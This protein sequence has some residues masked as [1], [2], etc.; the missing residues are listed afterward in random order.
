MDDF[1]R[2]VKKDDG[3]E[4]RGGNCDGGSMADSIWLVG[5]GKGVIYALYGVAFFNGDY[6]EPVVGVCDFSYCFSFMEEEMT[7]AFAR[8]AKNRNQSEPD[9]QPTV[10]QGEDDIGGSNVVMA[11]DEQ[12]YPD[13]P[14]EPNDINDDRAQTVD[15]GQDP[16]Y[17]DP[18]PADSGSGGDSSSSY[19]S[20]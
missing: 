2:T 14:I 3:I 10:E 15:V 13:V 11:E 7:A 12:G 16:A 8:L 4:L 19:S 6:S 5:D 18:T 17:S 9:A 20:D 1:L